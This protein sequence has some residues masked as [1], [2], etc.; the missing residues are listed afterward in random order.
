[1]AKCDICSKEIT[2]GIKV[3]HSHRRT[4]RTWKPNVKRVKALVNGTPCRIY[5]C[6]RCLRSGKVTRAI[7]DWYEKRV[8]KVRELT[9]RSFSF[10]FFIGY[11][12]CKWVALRYGVAPHRLRS[13]LPTAELTPAQILASLGNIGSLSDH[14]VCFRFQWASYYHLFRDIILPICIV[15]IIFCFW[16]KMSFK[17]IIILTLGRQRRPPL[18]FYNI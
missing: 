10:F 9:Q 17:Y 15:Y 4:N 14:T 11:Y 3:S 1:M 12:L 13:H 6:T 2:F 5:A 16:L 8:R 7:W 18:L